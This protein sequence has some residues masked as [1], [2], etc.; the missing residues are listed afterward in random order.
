MDLVE[1]ERELDALTALL[2]GLAGGRARTALI[3]GPAGIGKTRLLSAL[4]DA[5]GERG[6]RILNA[7]GSELERE[8]P[9]G[10]VRQ[11]FEPALR[12]A[13]NRTELFEGAAEI[14]GSVFGAPGEELGGSDASFAVLH[15][16]YWLTLDLAGDEPL[17]LAVDD[18][19]WSTT[20][21]RRDSA[22]W[23]TTAAPSCCARQARLP[24]GSPPTCCGCRRS[25][26]SGR[27]SC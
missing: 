27:R 1:R 21:C 3:E 16:L 25:A 23:S 24:S 8:F 2:D 10:V 14:A 5:A 13:P 12:E 4:K 17:L 6:L 19:Q 22:S 11:L 7:R 26:R 20:I 15:G 9:F 18:I